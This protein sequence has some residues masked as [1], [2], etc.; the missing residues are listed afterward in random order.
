MTGS[1]ITMTASLMYP[2][3]VPLLIH[4]KLTLSRC[5]LSLTSRVYHIDELQAFDNSCEDCG[6]P[7]SEVHGRVT[8][9]SLCFAVMLPTHNSDLILHQTYTQISA[10]TELSSG[11]KHG[12][13]Q[14]HVAS[15]FSKVLQKLVD[16]ID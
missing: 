6:D 11:A 16:R 14:S 10:N 3:M 1:S 12:N 7:F 9:T 2:P 5:T 4:P 8:T 13:L 15:L